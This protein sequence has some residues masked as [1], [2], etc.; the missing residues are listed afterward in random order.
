MADNHFSLIQLYELSDATKVADRDTN[1]HLRE[2]TH[3]MT[4]LRRFAETR[5][6]QIQFSGETADTLEN[7]KTSHVSL[8][9]L[10]EYSRGRHFGSHCEHLLDCEQCVG[11]LGFCHSARSVSD[12]IRML[13]EN[14]FVI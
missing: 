10:W 13:R 12:V 5:S 7:N 6:R 14:G 1:E 2:C 3:C 4:L 8:Q 11:I 9:L